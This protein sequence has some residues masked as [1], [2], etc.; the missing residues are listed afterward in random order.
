MDQ[1]G[2]MLDAPPGAGVEQAFVLADARPLHPPG[3]RHRGGAP[4]HGLGGRLAEAA[5]GTVCVTADGVP[6]SASGHDRQGR[7]GR[8]EAVEVRYGRQDPALFFPPPG[9]KR[10]DVGNLLAA[11]GQPS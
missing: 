3:Q 9:L 10:L 1:I 5:S 7:S 2:L 11:P 6:L 4:L 8:L